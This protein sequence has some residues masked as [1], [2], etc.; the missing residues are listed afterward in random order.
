MVVQTTPQPPPRPPQE[1]A[2]VCSRVL[3]TGAAFRALCLDALSPLSPLTAARA[4]FPPNPA[5]QAAPL[6]VTVVSIA[7]V[8]ATTGLPG[9]AVAGVAPAAPAY[10]PAA[11]GAPAACAGVVLRAD[12]VLRYAMGADGGGAQLAGAAVALTLGDAAEGGPALRAAVSVAWADA[13]A[14]PGAPVPR[15]GAPGYLEG[16]PVLAG[17]AAAQAGKAAVARLAAG[18]ALP[19]AAAGGG[20]GACAPGGGAGVRFGYNASASCSVAL[21]RPQ[22]AALCGG[23]DAAAA[24]RGVAG[25]AAGA[26]LDAAIAGTARLGVWGDSDP[27]AP[28]EWVPLAVAGWPPPAPAWSSAEG[29][30]SG[31]ATGYEIKI[32]TGASASASNP[33]R[34]LLR[35]QLCVTLGEW[36]Y[37][38]RAPGGAGGGLQQFPLRF[39]AR[40]AAAG[41]GAPAAALRP[42]PPLVAPLPP[43]LFYPFL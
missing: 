17:V 21:S 31:V 23:G 38:A 42:A 6:G 4:A 43:D 35:A 11:G 16:L 18:L 7:R 33:Q 36:R 40:F 25:G 12:W 15:S 22:L 37:D 13:A 8:N 19:G 9:A 34:K 20:G 10:T 39:G 30:C 27:A 29:R 1:D 28:A 41:Q 5:A 24:L 3:P 32:A 14:P 2:A 26:L